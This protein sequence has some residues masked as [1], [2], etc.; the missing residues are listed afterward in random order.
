MEFPGFNRRLARAPMTT[1]RH[2]QIFNELH[3]AIAAGQYEPGDKLPTEAELTELYGVSRTTVTRA[4]RDLQNE[5]ILE[6]RRGSGTYVARRDP[7]SSSR[8]DIAFFTPF[9]TSPGH[10]PHVEG[11]IHHYLASI[12]GRSPSQS[13][14]V[15]QC[16]SGDESE[17]IEVRFRDSA[18]RILESDVQG[19]LFYPAILPPEKMHLNQMAVDL[20]ATAGLEIVLVD[21]ELDCTP[22][23]SPFTRVGYDNVRAGFL[24]ADHLAQVGRRRMVFVGSSSVATAIEDRWTGFCA[25]LL[26]HGISPSPE[27]LLEPGD[28][29]TASFCKAFLD[30]M[31]PDAVVCYADRIVAQVGQH[32]AKMGVRAGED[33][34]LA[35]FGEEAVASLLPV[36]LTTVAFPAEPF[37]E[38][39]CE[40][41]LERIENS[42]LP[43]R[44]II[45]DT[46]LIVRQ[47]TS[48]RTE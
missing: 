25:G 43:I 16:L 22:H 6:R 2:R 30:E 15:Y 36:P 10:L 35:G 19:V 37:A 11:L 26:H 48:A 32:L 21:R 27:M 8:A 14:F 46:E 38:A 7:A 4:V 44:Q 34:A 31:R 40:A 24:I 33:I 5:G 9:V 47:S 17:S 12:I 23:R 41:I 18:R 3:Q 42:D 45:I 13:R 20:L 29:V 28:T 1:P 39:A